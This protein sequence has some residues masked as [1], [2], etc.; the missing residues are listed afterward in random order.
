M[1]PIRSND[2]TSATYTLDTLANQYQSVKPIR[3]EKKQIEVSDQEVFLLLDHAH[4]IWPFIFWTM[5]A[6]I[7]ALMWL[8]FIDS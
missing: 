2:H 5:F 8:G 4:K 1:Q 3:T 7:I 6:I